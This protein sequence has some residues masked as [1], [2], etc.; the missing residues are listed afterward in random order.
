M[1]FE[2]RQPRIESALET[3]GEEIETTEAEREAF[4]DFLARLREID[5]TESPAT[6]AA[7]AA[8]AG[9]ASELVTPNSGR[10]GPMQEVRT[11]YRGTVMAVSHYEDEYDDSLIESLA[12]EYGDDI[13]RCVATETAVAPHVY[14]ALV[15]TTEEIRSRRSRFVTA[16][17]RERDS[18]RRIERELDECE[19]RALKLGERIADSDG[20]EELGRI[21]EELQELESTCRSLSE[22]RQGVIHGRSVA[23]LSGVS[24]LSLSAYL[25]ADHES[26]CPALADIAACLASIRHAR[27]N[28]L[29]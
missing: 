28:C 10:S 3:V 1:T 20:T 11:A 25:Y 17:R 5:R 8:N 12:A 2:T 7:V 16:L 21:D 13:A 27:E 23:K 4:E 18:L 24:D 26:I 19:S 9:S 29:R 14:D 15:E 22:R 6:N